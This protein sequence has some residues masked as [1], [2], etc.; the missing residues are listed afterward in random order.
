M[1]VGGGL[2]A[3]SKWLGV[4]KIGLAEV[5]ETLRRHRC[6]QVKAR[7]LAWVGQGKAP[8]GPCAP[9]PNTSRYPRRQ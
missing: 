1:V 9:V 8:D 2:A 7:L 6:L 4:L 5:E 3:A